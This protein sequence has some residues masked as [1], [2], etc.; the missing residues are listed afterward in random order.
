MAEK[1]IVCKACGVKLPRSKVQE[2]ERI[3][4]S[5]HLDTCE[6]K[7]ARL[8]GFGVSWIAEH[9]GPID[10]C[11]PPEETLSSTQTVS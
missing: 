10:P 6:F 3:Q 9:G 7:V 5:A 11:D 2:F 8:Q 1:W 4:Y